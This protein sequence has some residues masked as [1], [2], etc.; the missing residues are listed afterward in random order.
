MLAVQSHPSLFYQLYRSIL[1]TTHQ[2]LF[3]LTHISIACSSFKELQ[4]PS[5]GFMGCR[6]MGC[7]WCEITLGWK[8]II[9]SCKRFT[10]FLTTNEN[11]AISR[12]H[13]LL[14]HL[15]VYK[16]NDYCLN[17][18]RQHLMVISFFCHRKQGGVSYC[19]I[20]QKP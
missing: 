5:K 14:S 3:Y 8:N 11:L 2:L 15:T 18:N 13:A 1:F 20:A 6:L 10:D 4:S 12:E 9:H 17:S 7:V 19:L 16:L